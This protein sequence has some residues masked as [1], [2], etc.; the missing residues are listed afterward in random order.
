MFNRQ[1]SCFWNPKPRDNFLSD[2]ASSINIDTKKVRNGQIHFGLN[3]TFGRDKK[4]K[5][6]DEEDE[7]RAKPVS[8]SSEKSNESSNQSNT[9]KKLTII[10]KE[11]LTKI[12]SL[13]KPR[14]LNLLIIQKQRRKRILEKGN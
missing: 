10:Q 9:P 1:C 3:L 4:E 5:P 13:K 12:K 2:A 11:V 6:I 14:T 7:N 8:S